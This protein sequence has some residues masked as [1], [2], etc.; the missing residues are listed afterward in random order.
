M[1]YHTDTPTTPVLESPR[2]H[3]TLWALAVFLFG[4]VDVAS[5]MYFVATTPAVEGHPLIAAAIG[6][7]GL[8]ILVP[9][10]AAAIGLFYGLYRL[11]PQAYRIGVPLGLTGVGAVVSMWNLHL[12]LSA[13]ALV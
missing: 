10:K 8:W 3:A 6:A 11:T 1:H 2:V 12:G 7:T 9:W 5:T 13:A 4:V